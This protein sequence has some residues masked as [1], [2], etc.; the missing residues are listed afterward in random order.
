MTGQAATMVRS[1]RAALAIGWFA[2]FC[3]C[4]P[5]VAAAQGARTVK[6]VISVPPGGTIDFLVRVLADHI[7][8]ANGQTVIVES[9]PGASGI[10][11]AE[12]VAR[13]APDGA[14]LLVN[15]NGMIIASYLRKVSFD[16]LTS[17][18]P[19]CF[20][21]SSPQVLV[22]NAA[23]PYRSFTEF[24]AAA[25]ADP[26][27]LS[28]ATVG[29]NTTQ[30]LAVERLKRRAGV[31]LTYVPFTGGAPAINALLGN[32]VTA[33]LQNFSEIGPQ[34]KA[35]TLRARSPRPRP[36]ASS[37]CR[38]CRPSPNSASRISPP[39]SGSGW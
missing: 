24:V 6:V 22:V 2:A 8:K 35:G 23:S 33:V 3:L 38:S 20:L 30:H 28:I 32:H 9:K 14:T 39:T 7:G 37:R 29:P 15:T 17:F 1:R 25:R 4:A 19:I 27:A 10:I 31:N 26:G 34:L 18:E 5:L 11:A 36:S 21:V 12:T 16:P 13:A